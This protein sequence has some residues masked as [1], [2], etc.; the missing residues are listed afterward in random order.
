M[1]T[2]SIKPMKSRW[3]SC[4][5]RLNKINLNLKLIHQERKAI[6]YVITHELIHLV[7]Q[8]HSESFYKELKKVMPDYL[9]RKNYLSSKYIHI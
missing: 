6:E 5:K 8:N 9:E 1:P 7:V 4:N 3:G 2:I